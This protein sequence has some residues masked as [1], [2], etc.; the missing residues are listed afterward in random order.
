MRIAK[1][2]AAVAIAALAFGVPAG[3][4][5]LTFSLS[6]A[7]TGNLFQT[8]ASGSD[9]ITMAG[10]SF[11]KSL[12]SFSVFASVDTTF[13][14]QNSGLND[15]DFSAGV[16]YV[17]ALGPKTAA[18]FALQGEMVRHRTEYVDFDRS[19]VRLT[20]SLKTYLSPSSIFK[21]VSATEYRAYGSSPFDFFSHGLTASL[22]KYFPTKTTFKAEAAWGFKYFLHPWLA[23]PAPTDGV[24]GAAETFELTP[25]DGFSPGDDTPG[26]KPE[27]PGSGGPGQ[28]SGSGGSDGTPGNG[29]PS[30]GSGGQGTLG[31][32]WRS[33]RGS[34]YAY[35]AGE[36]GQGIQM[37]SANA[38]LAQGI[39]NRVG[40]R[41]AGV[42]QKTLS[43]RNPFS[44]VEEFAMIENPTY[45]A[46]AWQGWGWN[47]QAS[48]VLPWSIELR[49]GYTWTDKEFPGIESLDLDGAPLG[50]TRRDKRDQIDVKLEKSFKRWSA[51]LSY[52]HIRNR[53]NDPLYAW[54]GPFVSLS[55]QWSPAIGKKK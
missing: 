8:L 47:A 2:A 54:S 1:T 16:D 20:A 37:A 44:A 50:L 45:D 28:G 14:W 51:V 26:K 42:L 34:G 39:G 36:G 53:S 29:T 25:N 12:S 41:L 32:S 40:L 35:A 30:P 7:Y 3:A 22:D 52:G 23:A 6:Q 38:A 17:A 27:A 9:R 24:A 33:S 5:T 15:L 4:D 48:A 11:E 18:Y 55:L 31:S 49:L 43:G 10:L 19:G 21:A 13:L 46:F